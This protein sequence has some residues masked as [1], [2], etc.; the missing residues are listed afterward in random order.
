[1]LT[2]ESGIQRDVVRDQCYSKKDMK[3]KITDYFGDSVIVSSI[4]G[5]HDIISLRQNTSS[6]VHEFY[7]HSTGMTD[8]EKK[9]QIIDM[10]AKRIT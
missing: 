3:K 8:D 5:K 1:M 7:E 6:F 9:Q 2:L 10:A 4:D